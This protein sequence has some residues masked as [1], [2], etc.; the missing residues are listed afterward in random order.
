M[1]KGVKVIVCG[2]VM[3]NG[4][5]PDVG[6]VIEIDRA[7]YEQAQDNYQAH[8]DRATNPAAYAAVQV[9]TG[10]RDMTPAEERAAL[11]AEQED[12]KRQL[13]EALEEIARLDPEHRSTA[14]MMRGVDACMAELQA[15][16]AQ[17][18]EQETRARSLGYQTCPLCEGASMGGP[19]CGLCG[20]LGF[21]P[22]PKAKG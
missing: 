16:I 15:L 10:V 8:G 2:R 19:V 5:T 14:E 21:T 22:I 13:A 18:A 4:R 17:R 3:R 9:G 1:S 20:H 11:E 6:S 12:L 7:E